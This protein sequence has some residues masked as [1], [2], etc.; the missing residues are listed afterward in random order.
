MWKK[1]DQ[2]NYITCRSTDMGSG[3]YEIWNTDDKWV[4][5]VGHVQLGEIGD[6]LEW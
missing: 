4:L 5:G 6:F 2:N 3:K 1:L